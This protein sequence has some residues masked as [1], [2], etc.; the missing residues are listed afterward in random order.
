[1]EEQRKQTQDAINFRDSSRNT[2]YQADDEIRPLIERIQDKT[3]KRDELYKL[4][5]QVAD[6]IK[7]IA[8]NVEIATE[9]GGPLMEGRIEH[10]NPKRANAKRYGNFV[11]QRFFLVTFKDD[12]HSTLGVVS[13]DDPL[14]LEQ[15]Q[16]FDTDDPWSVT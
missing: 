16:F 9:G 10:I 5:S 11:A 1:L 2:F 4:R 13:P 3:A 7:S 12:R 14:D 6:R 15:Y 8:E